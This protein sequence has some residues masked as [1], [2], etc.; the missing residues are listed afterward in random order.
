LPDP[1][2]VASP[3]DKSAL[4]DKTASAPVPALMA[5]TSN[6]VEP[7]KKAMSASG[8][9]RS[10]AKAC[11]RTGWGRLAATVT[12]ALTPAAS[13][14]VPDTEPTSA[15]VLDSNTKPTSGFVLD[16][17]TEPTSGFVPVPETDSDLMLTNEDQSSWDSSRVLAVNEWEKEQS[18][19]YEDEESFWSANWMHEGQIVRGFP[20]LNPENNLADYVPVFIKYTCSD[21]SDPKRVM[22]NDFI[23]TNAFNDEC[24]RLGVNK[25][26]ILEINKPPQTT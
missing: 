1:A 13:V 4:A 19:T 23:N 15:S 24:D 10:I 18:Q 14:S 16:S 12:C 22:W 6:T 2:T 3:A 7:V 20:K 26:E 21:P 8:T 9:M 25:D 5:V 11:E 17:N